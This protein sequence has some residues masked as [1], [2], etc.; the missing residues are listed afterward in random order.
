MLT[1]I[2]LFVF[3]LGLL[4]LVH[5][6]GHFLIARRSGVGVEEF[7][8]GFP[9]RLFGIKKGETLYSINLIPLGGFVRLKGVPGDTKNPD[10]VKAKDSYARRPYWVKSL[11][12]SGGVLM[13]LALAWVLLTVGFTMGLP[14]SVD[15]TNI[16]RAENVSVQVGQVLP[17]SPAEH[18]GLRVGDVIVAIDGMAIE[19]ADDVRTYN[20]NQ[21]AESVSVTVKRGEEEFTQSISLETI[22]GEEK[23]LGVVLVKTGIVKYPWYQSIWLGLKQTFTLLVVIILAFGGLLR[24]LLFNGTVSAEV[25]GPVGIAVLTGHVAELGFIYLLQF[26]AILSINLAI[27]NFFP[28]PALDGGRFLFATIEKIRGKAVS[29]RV[30]TIIHNMGFTL[31]ILLVLLIT[32][33]DI[34]K[35]FE[36][37]RNLFTSL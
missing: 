20:Q 17:E 14:T 2:I 18:G 22:E 24:E 3:I 23:I 25:A 13:N 36:P 26:T 32:I 8:F 4:V 27:I 19:E 11:I 28:F 15:E 5:E 29:P 34:T 10:D 31:L 9:P 33:R 30:E 16:D 7:G 6:L 37:L 12:L 21:A 35:I 1:T